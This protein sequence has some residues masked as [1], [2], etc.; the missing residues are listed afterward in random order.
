[1]CRQTCAQQNVVHSCAA[2]LCVAHS[3]LTNTPDA[4]ACPTTSGLWQVGDD[5][6]EVRLAQAQVLM[7]C[8]ADL[9]SQK[10]LEGTRAWCDSG[11]RLRCRSSEQATSWIVFGR[12]P[13]EEG[14]G[15]IAAD[16]CSNKATLEPMPAKGV[17]SAATTQPVQGEIDCLAH[18][19]K[20]PSECLRSTAVSMLLSQSQHN[21]GHNCSL[22]KSDGFR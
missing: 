6:E 5:E 14:E 1:M 17:Q 20:R 13:E 9:L 18:H 8:M 15:M 12:L 11:I 2:C 22:S 10:G 16:A 21:N 3:E 4:A 19:C 7:D